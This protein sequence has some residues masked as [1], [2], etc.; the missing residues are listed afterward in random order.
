MATASEA[1]IYDP[2]LL[3]E[4]L[5]AATPDNPVATQADLANLPSPEQTLYDALGNQTDGAP[6]N[7]LLNSNLSTLLARLYGLSDRLDLLAKFIIRWDQEKRI[8]L[9]SDTQGGLL[10]A[11]GQAFAYTPGAYTA[12]IIR[13]RAQDYGRNG[14]LIAV[15]IAAG[16]KDLVFSK[17]TAQAFH[18]ASGPTTI[19]A[20]AGQQYIFHLVMPDPQ[21]TDGSFWQVHSSPSTGSG[22]PGP[23]YTAGDGISISA[24]N[25]ISLTDTRDPFAVGD[26]AAITSAVLDLS[27]TWVKGDLTAFGSDALRNAGAPPAISG[28]NSSI[29]VGTADVA[30]MDEFDKTDANG[31]AWR[32]RYS[33]RNDGTSGWTRLGKTA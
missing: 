19:P 25:V 1:P 26:N 16:G 21:T 24:D 17:G 29:L 28:Q 8:V 23:T 9:D 20:L 2:G 13:L 3:A 5:G 22:T 12:G 32:C 11:S 10:Y 31:N 6:T 7:R 15:R 14:D 4:Q 27:N 18:S 33:R 30:T